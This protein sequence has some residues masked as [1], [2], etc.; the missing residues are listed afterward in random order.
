[1]KQITAW[2]PI[3]EDNFESRSRIM[4][5]NLCMKVVSPMV[6]SLTLPWFFEKQ[7]IAQETTLALCE[8]PSQTVRIYSMGGQSYLRAF[9]R[10]DGVVWMNQTP[11]RTEIA[12]EGTR[13]TSLRGEQTVSLFVNRDANN[14]AIQIRNYQPEF[15]TLLEVNTT[16]SDYTLQQSR[17]IH[18]QQVSE[19]E[20]AC[21]APATL[22]A[23][24]FQNEGQPQRATF[25]CWSALD[26][27]GTQTGEW[28]G[29]LPLAQNDPTFI[30]PL[31]CPSGDQACQ[32]QLELMRSRF[33]E[34]LAQAELTCSIK[35]GTLFFAPA[36]QS[37]DIRCGYFATTFWDMNGDGNPDNSSSA[38]V[39][40]SVG[41]LPLLGNGSL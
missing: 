36:E 39:D 6:L 17:R 25:I 4:H 23:R 27:D 8:T 9:D 3:D 20:D 30:K 1:M 24:P 32:S 19:F 35:D 38:S 5:P 7:A 16:M 33:P 12:P 15:G 2:T 40:M 22:G 29:I 41:L 11:V 21:K 26:S 34:Q 28:F 18:P 14:C 31:T 10:Q 37:V 13:Y